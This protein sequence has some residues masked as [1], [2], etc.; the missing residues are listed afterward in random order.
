M[1]NFLKNSLAKSL[2]FMQFDT[3]HKV[4][5]LAGKDTEI[6]RKFTKIYRI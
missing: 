4:K 3:S 1:G 5:E 2:N 6:V